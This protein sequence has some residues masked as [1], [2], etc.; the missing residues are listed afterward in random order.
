MVLR[1]QLVDQQI[2]VVL[3]QLKSYILQLYIASPSLPLPLLPPSCTV[4]CYLL[5]FRLSEMGMVV[6]RRLI[7]SLNIAKMHKVQTCAVL[8]SHL[9]SSSSLQFL[10]FTLRDDNLN[11]WIRSEVATP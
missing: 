4:V 7:H 6:W 8:T 10:S 5:L 2:A 9:T 11:G 3:N 1:S